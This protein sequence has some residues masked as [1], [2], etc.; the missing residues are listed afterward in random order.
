MRWQHVTETGHDECRLV[1]SSEGF[2]L[3]GVAFL[4]LESAPAELHYSV[5]CCTSFCTRRARVSGTI[6]LH[7]VAFDITK[8]ARGWLMNGALAPGVDVD[9]GFTPATNLLPIRR[10]ALLPGQ[11]AEAPAAWLDAGRGTLT[12][13]AQRYERRG[14]SRYW[15]SAPSVG[16]EALLAVDELGFVVDY[17]GLWRAA[18]GGNRTQ[19]KGR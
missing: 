1:R 10:L 2:A 19:R 5:L 4:Q 11:A 16:F 17:P 18:P 7:P 12:R 13:L 14:A 8:S 6:G 9:L 3:E 15:Y